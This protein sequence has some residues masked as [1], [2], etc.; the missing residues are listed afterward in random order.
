MLRY[1]ITAVCKKYYK[2]KEEQLQARDKRKSLGTFHLSPFTFR[3][4][5]RIILEAG[6]EPSLVCD[7]DMAIALSYT[8]KA[9]V[10]GILC[11]GKYANKQDNL[12]P[13]RFNFQVDLY[14]ATKFLTHVADQDIERMLV[15]KECIKTTIVPLSQGDTKTCLGN[16][17]TV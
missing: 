9:K 2:R 14:S 13:V 5:T 17:S 10:K 3:R 16:D 12:R 7:G 6:V 15:P 11:V 8:E 1:A 4:F